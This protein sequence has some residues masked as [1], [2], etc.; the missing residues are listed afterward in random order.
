MGAPFNDVGGGTFVAE[1]DPSPGGK[2]IRTWFFPFG[3]E[4]TD[5]IE[6]TP[7]PDTW[8]LPFAH[9]SLDP[10]VCPASHFSNMRLVFDLTFCGDLGNPTFSKR[11][12]TEAA[13]MRCDEFVATQS[14]PEAY[15]GVR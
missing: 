1:W 10:S 7:M 14:L 6:H 5:L 8:S 3:S 4:P 11:C 13:R 9:F 12:P 2:G 15:W